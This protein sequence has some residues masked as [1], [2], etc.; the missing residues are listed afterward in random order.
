MRLT[1]LTMHGRTSFGGVA[2]ISGG[3]TSSLASFRYLK[4][5]AKHPLNSTKS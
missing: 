3:E 4:S 1:M 5:S 2:D